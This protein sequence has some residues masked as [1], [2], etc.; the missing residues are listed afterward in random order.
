[1]ENFEKLSKLESAVLQKLEIPVVFEP[2]LLSNSIETHETTV[3]YA[4]EKVTDEPG[5]IEEIKSGIQQQPLSE[6][7]DLLIINKF[8][9]NLQPLLESQSIRSFKVEEEMKISNESPLSTAPASVTST[10]NESFLTTNEVEE[11]PISISTSTALT[12]IKP[13][14][15]YR[16]SNVKSVESH[17]IQQKL[18]SLSS[19][20]NIDLDSLISREEKI[21]CLEERSQQQQPISA[22]TIRTNE[23]TDA[24]FSSKLRFFNKV[25]TPTQPRSATIHTHIS[26]SNTQPAQRAVATATKPTSLN[27]SLSS[28]LMNKRFV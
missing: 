27:Y 15:D 10:V 25:S 9:S 18:S 17:F 21:N 23:S 4:P 19:K 3:E 8:Y 24:D 5:F 1:M 11:I 13:A 22:A 6:L 28:S 14:Y 26:S 2:R 12:Q 7:S 16:Y 20:F